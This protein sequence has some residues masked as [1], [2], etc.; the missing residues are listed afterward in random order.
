MS[1]SYLIVS[2]VL[3]CVIMSLFNPTGSW[4]TKRLGGEAPH[5]F[6]SLNL[7]WQWRQQEDL[8]FMTDCEKRT[9]WWGSKRRF[10][11]YREILQQIG[12]IYL[13]RSEISVFNWSLEGQYYEIIHPGRRIL[14]SRLN[15]SHLDWVVRG[16]R[17][18]QIFNVW[19]ILLKP[20][21]F[22]PS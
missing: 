16:D 7:E 4:A 10:L 14:V 6:F 9:P 22:C 11:I 18:D 5:F 1:S 8:R 21:S 2:D 15:G 20:C 19:V 3:L 17:G 13:L 12:E